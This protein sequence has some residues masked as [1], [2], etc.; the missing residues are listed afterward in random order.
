MT[1]LNVNGRAYDIPESWD[2]ETLLMVLREQLGLVGAKFGCGDGEC[3]TCVVLVD[4]RPTRSCMLPA[5]AV[6]GREILTIEGLAGPDGTLHP[7]QQSWVDEGVAQCGYCQSGQI[8][9]AYALLKRNPQPT[10]A[11]IVDWMQDNLCR[12]GTY[13]RAMRAILRSVE[14]DKT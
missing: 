3:G 8:L 4:D 10:E 2:D 7:L 1:T 9:Q 5:A 14:A 6:A 11:D 12:C 13:A